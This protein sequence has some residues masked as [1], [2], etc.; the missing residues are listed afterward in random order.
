[1]RR[2]LLFT[3]P[4][5]VAFVSFAQHSDLISVTEQKRFSALRDYDLHS[6]ASNNF[7]VTF[8]RCNWT[9][10]PAVKFI[11]GS[12]T[13]YFNITATTN[14]I[15]YDLSNALTVDSIVFRNSKITFSQT[16]ANALVINFPSTLTPGQKDSVSIYYR[17]VPPNASAFTQSTH[18]N[19]R[20]I[21][22]LSEP[23]GASTWWPC[24]DVLKDKADS[25]DIIITNPSAF[26]SSS[27]GLPVAETVSGNNRTTYW[28]HRY[29]I[30]AYLVALAVTNYSV[31]T[32][33]AT[34]P[35]RTMPMAIYA[36]PESVTGF[37]PALTIAKFC[38][39]EYSKLLIE[40]P[41]SRERYAQTQFGAGGGMEHQT[42]SYIV[43][44]D[45]LLVAHELGHQWFGDRV[46]CGSW[47]DIWL[48]EGWAT[49][50]EYIYTELSN[51]SGRLSML[52]TWRNTV[53]SAPNGSVYVSGVDTLNESRLFSTRL[54]Y[55]KG[56]YLVHMLRWK[57][58][59]SSFFRGVRRYLNDPLLAYNTA[60]S[61][62][63]KRNLELE[64]GLNLTEFFN[65]WLYG[66]GY[67]DY[68]AVWS[69]QSNFNV[70]LKLNQTPSHSSV[71]FFEMPV[72]V[73]FRNATRD[74]ILRVEH[75]ENG[76]IFNLNPGFIADTVIIDPDLWILSK[77]K[78]AVKGVVTA[79]NDPSINNPVVITPNPSRG[80]FDIHLSGNNPRPI[81]IEMIN[82]AGQTVYERTVS[83]DAK[84]V[85]VDGSREAS[86]IY[87]IRLSDAR[88][89]GIVKKLALLTRR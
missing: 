44:A 1:M 78:L 34:L 57:L 30:A 83:G 3:L 88:G 23:Y 21:W 8:Y 16:A 28:K 37:T 66:E 62:D 49:Y 50:M 20:I 18:N 58:G 61:A 25:I 52:Q 48:N 77:N 55:R 15:T 86:G 73:L 33:V 81:R 32:D 79:V 60:L 51:P 10:D 89:L 47:S 29:P 87:W 42:N 85:T 63:F 17:G 22:T 53:V 36:Y 54:T 71:S 68:N 82:S 84:L 5:L 65:D 45:N 46:T 40:Y 67:P 80:I 41:F 24:K 27:N 12:V 74:T 38:L 76:Q 70:Q 14:S 7:D 59:D 72:P 31:S 35:S 64:S 39:Q 43:N 6:V 9:I 2:I 19:T 11:S 13:S 4:L 56:G 75:T 26:I 69:Q